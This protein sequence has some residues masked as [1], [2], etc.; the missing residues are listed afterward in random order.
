MPQGP[1]TRIVLKRTN[2][3]TDIIGRQGHLDPHAAARTFAAHGKVT[4]V[5][6]EMMPVGPQGKPTGAKAQTVAIHHLR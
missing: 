3:R 1:Y 6:H 2:G 5:R 4:V